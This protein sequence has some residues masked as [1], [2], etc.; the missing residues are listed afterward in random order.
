MFVCLTSNLA[1]AVCFAFLV[2]FIVSIEVKV[3]VQ[4]TQPF[5]H[6]VGCC[7]RDGISPTNRLSM[8][9]SETIQLP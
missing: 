9:L 5:D 1:I 7:F 6:G 4:I 2:L 3:L 8:V